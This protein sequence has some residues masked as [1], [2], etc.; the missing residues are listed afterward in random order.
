MV[1][2]DGCCFTRFP[3]VAPL[4]SEPPKPGISSCA[5]AAG[6]IEGQLMSVRRQDNDGMA[7]RPQIGR[8]TIAVARMRYDDGT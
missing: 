2:N 5:V 3:R 8:R 6:L 1:C 7:G 4:P